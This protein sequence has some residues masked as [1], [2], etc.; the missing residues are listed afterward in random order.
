MLRAKNDIEIY[1]LKTLELCKE[2][3]FSINAQW[4]NWDEYLR[5]YPDLKTNGVTGKESAIRHWTR[6][7]F[8]EN[9]ELTSIYS[10]QSKE[11]K[12]FLTCKENLKA[13]FH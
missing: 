10:T 8:R 9:R 2:K 6:F 13:N 7:G 11:K 3:T 5:K 4:F 12:F 1:R